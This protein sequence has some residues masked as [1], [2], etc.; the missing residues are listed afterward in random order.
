MSRSTKR[1]GMSAV[2]SRRAEASQENK[3]A[4]KGESRCKAELKAWRTIGGNLPDRDAPKKWREDGR[5]NGRERSGW[6]EE[7]LR[8]ERKRSGRWMDG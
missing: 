3:K 6:V 4:R 1:L 8:R 7:R 2:A 5:M